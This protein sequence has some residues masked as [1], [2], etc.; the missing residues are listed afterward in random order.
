MNDFE[1]LF[2]FYA[3]LLGLSVANVASGFGDMWRERHAMPIGVCTPLIGLVVLAGGMNIWV[4]YWHTQ[5]D[6][7][8]SPWWLLSAVGV[9]VPFIF[10]SRAM[11]PTPSERKSLEEHYMAQR[12]V[13]LLA[14]TVPPCVSAGSNLLA[15]NLYTGWP[16]VWMALRIAAP[17]A[18]IPFNSRIVQRIGLSLFAALLLL[19]MFRW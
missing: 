3:L 11:F 2:S 14:L 1:Y 6:V 7:H 5:H 16:A 10:V 19:G 8:F 17:L 12:K 4:R 13:L 9:T 18:L 15:G